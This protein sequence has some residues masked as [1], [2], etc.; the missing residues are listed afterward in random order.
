[1]KKLVCI[2]CP[3]SCELSIEETSDGI[4]VSGN[5]CKRGIKFATDEMTAPKRTISSVV[6]TAFKEAPVLP[7][8]VSDEI[9]KE[10]IFDVMNEINHVTVKKKLKRGDVVIKNVLS[11]G[12]DVIATSDVLQSVSE[13]EKEEKPKK[14]S[15]KKKAPAA[16]AKKKTK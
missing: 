16:K 9:P 15:A 8:R 14:T 11:L 5:K 10:R 13:E 7:V 2:V 1:M 3:N 12:V 6:K 4:N